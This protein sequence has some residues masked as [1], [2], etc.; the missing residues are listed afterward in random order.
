MPVVELEKRKGEP[1]RIFY[2]RGRFEAPVVEEQPEREEITV[3]MDTLQ[4]G[5][6]YRSL[7]AAGALGRIGMPAVE[8]LVQALTDTATTARWRIAIA[9]ASVGTPAAEALIEVVN[10]GKD[11]A[12]NPAIW[13]LGRI[14]DPRAVEPLITA[15]K[16]G[17]T[18][19]SR[20]LAAAALM[21]MGH[22]AG[23]AAVE[24]ALPAADETVRA[25]V[26]EEVH[27]N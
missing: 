3:L 6:T 15:M 12:A 23:I 10:A 24:E 8:P 26:L 4:K 13:A 17:R 14:G 5:D 11:P 18:E 27:R 9:L 7:Q 21:K 2:T 16:A 19:S 20:A 25:F 22:P 1:G